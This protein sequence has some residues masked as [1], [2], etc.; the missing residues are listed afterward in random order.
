MLNGSANRCTTAKR[1]DR[2]VSPSALA[3]GDDLAEDAAVAL[4]ATVEPVGTVPSGQDIQPRSA[5]EGVIASLAEQVV[6][7]VIAV[8]HV[9]AVARAARCRLWTR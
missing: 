7:S 2:D 9:V 4:R 8:D 3:C 5:E 1:P 6:V